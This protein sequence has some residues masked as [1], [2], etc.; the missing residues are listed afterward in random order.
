MEQ[1]VALVGRPNVGKSTLFNCLI[2][3]K[4]SITHERAGT[5]L[6]VIYGEVKVG[7]KR[8]RVGDAP[9]VFENLSDSLN[10]MAEERA[11]KL[12][13]AAKL[14]IFV[15][16]ST[17]PMTREDRNIL[18]WIRKNNLPF[19]VCA[20][21]ADAKTSEENVKEAK[22]L[23]GKDI[24]SVAA[25]QKQGTDVLAKAII[26][27]LESKVASKDSDEGEDAGMKQIKVAILG[28]PNVGKSSL[29]NQ[30]IGEDRSL[31]SEIPGTTRDSIDSVRKYPKL[32]MVIRWI[33]TAG[34]RRRNRIS[35]E[36]EYI[37]HIKSHNI[38]EECDMAVLLLGTDQGIVRQD[39]TIIRH[40]LE[41][42]KALIIALSKTDLLNKTGIKKW[43]KNIYEKVLPYI[44]WVPLVPVSISNGDA[45][46]DLLGTIRKV[47]HEYTKKIPTKT[48]NKFFTDF[49]AMH[50]APFVKGKRAKMYYG[51]QMSAAPPEFMVFANDADLFR[52]AYLRTIEN[53]LRER[54]SFLGCPLVI[55][56]RSKKDSSPNPYY[57]E[58][59]R[60]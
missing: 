11:L 23:I 16:D 48:L 32:G 47:Y 15:I 34:L 10:K 2:G 46:Q 42:K 59:R 29:F 33:D 8:F 57:R 55:N 13:A 14:L 20:T 28:R 9:G 26:K 22:R 35:D 44:T 40:I 5:T 45:V 3:K 36:L 60:R 30:L 31:V 49:Q 19:I 4:K 12:F 18:A 54:F 25:M 43:Q 24:Y 17:V 37:T 41:Q 58:R 56:F 52:F 21:K 51:V 7:K 1:F 50:T 6:D 38:I 39:E 27:L 53:E